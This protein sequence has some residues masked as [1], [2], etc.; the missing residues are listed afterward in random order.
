VNRRNEIMK[1]GKKER[2]GFARQ[3]EDKW[4]KEKE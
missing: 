2:R 1:N 3:K 4:N